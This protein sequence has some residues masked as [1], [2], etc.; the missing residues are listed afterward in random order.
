MKYFFPFFLLVLAGVA[1]QQALSPADVADIEATGAIIA[2]C[3]AEGFAC[4]ADGGTNCYDEAY[5][6][7]MRDAGLWQ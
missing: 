5:G 2:K 3:Q 1:C 6:A 7:C 4:K